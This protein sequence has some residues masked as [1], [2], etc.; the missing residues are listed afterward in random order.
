MIESLRSVLKTYGS[1]PARTGKPG[2]VCG[3]TR[4]GLKYV[5]DVIDGE[6]EMPAV[7]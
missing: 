5:F 1:S 3:T 6:I 4:S 7:E 2:R